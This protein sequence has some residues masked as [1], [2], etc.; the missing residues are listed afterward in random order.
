MFVPGLL[1]MCKVNHHHTRSITVST[2]HRACLVT[3]Q[4]RP[5]LSSTPVIMSTVGALRE[6]N[7][8]RLSVGRLS[9]RTAEYSWDPGLRP[10]GVSTC[11]NR[12]G[13][14]LFR[15]TVWSMIKDM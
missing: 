7:I 1:R 6:F 5:S 2:T 14:E 4:L 13:D 11:Y 3:L 9:S 8:V 10:T 12:A 15:V